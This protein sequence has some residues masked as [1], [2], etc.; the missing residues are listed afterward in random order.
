M[1]NFN[2][3]NGNLKNFITAGNS[4]CSALV[5]RT[6]DNLHWRLHPALFCRWRYVVV[7]PLTKWRTSSSG[8]TTPPPSTLTFTTPRWTFMVLRR[9][10][11][12]LWRMRRGSEETSSLWAL[13]TSPE[14]WL[15][16]FSRLCNLPPPHLL[17]ADS[18]AAWRC[19]YQG[20]E[21]VQR[22]VCCQSHLWPYE[23]HLVWNQ[24]GLE[25]CFQLQL[26]ASVKTVF[27]IMVYPWV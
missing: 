11:T 5:K 20:Q 27:Q 22:H 14:H 25:L 16:T 18:A 7:S 13:A 8:E 21:A 2:L 26:Y 23:G 12:R 19:C 24:G 17:P 3:K 4:W 10:C 6:E 9:A 15:V 1:V